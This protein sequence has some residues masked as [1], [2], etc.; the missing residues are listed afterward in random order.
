MDEPMEEN[1]VL[2]AAANKLASSENLVAKMISNTNMSDFIAVTHTISNNDGFIYYDGSK[3][4]MTVA[5]RYVF[6]GREIDDVAVKTAE[7]HLS[8]SLEKGAGHQQV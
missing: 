5:D 7:D 2:F 1:K 6:L 8:V 3:F 4:I